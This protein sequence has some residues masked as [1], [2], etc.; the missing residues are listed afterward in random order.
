MQKR[1]KNECFGP[2]FEVG[3]LVFDLIVHVLILPDVPNDS[4]SLVHS[5]CSVRSVCSLLTD[6]EHA[7]VVRYSC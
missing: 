2:F 6:V 4:V 5:V 3:P 7:R 1:P